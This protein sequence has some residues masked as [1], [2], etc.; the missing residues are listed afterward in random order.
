[1]ERAGPLSRDELIALIEAQAAQIAVLTA[2]IAELEAKLAVPPKNLGN[3]G[4]P[5]SK[6]PVA[7][8]FTPRGG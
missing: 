2:H 3:S 8:G 5:P 7:P 6:P 1:M 4:L